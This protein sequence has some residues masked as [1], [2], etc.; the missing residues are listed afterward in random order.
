MQAS[1]SL[2]YEP[3][4]ES[5][6][7]HRNSGTETRTHQLGNRKSKPSSHLKASNRRYVERV[8]A[9]LT[10]LMSRKLPNFQI[11]SDKFCTSNVFTQTDRVVNIDFYHTYWLIKFATLE[12]FVQKGVNLSE[13]GSTIFEDT[14]PS[15]N[16]GTNTLTSQSNPRT[17]P[18]LSRTPE[19]PCDPRV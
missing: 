14:D 4:S 17:A 9:A 15:L 12:V 1:M 8:S 3:S 13:T 19:P 16:P 6:S 18:P 2:Q 10:Q 5:P 11:L 7:L